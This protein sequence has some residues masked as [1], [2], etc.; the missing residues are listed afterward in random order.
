MGYVHPHI[1]T[2]REDKNFYVS[3]WKIKSNFYMLFLIRRF[4]V[5]FFPEVLSGKWKYD[6]LLDGGNDI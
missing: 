5:L 3:F 1:Q 4:R 6:K 2:Y